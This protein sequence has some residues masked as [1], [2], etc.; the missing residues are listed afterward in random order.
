MSALRERIIRGGGDGASRS[1]PAYT[2]KPGTAP[3]AT[4]FCL[5]VLSALGPSRPSDA[6]RPLQTAVRPHLS[7]S[8]EAPISSSLLHQGVYTRMIIAGGVRMQERNQ[9]K[10]EK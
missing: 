1:F 4:V 6:F 10:S 8:H 2:R 7:G 3:I 9:K 5:I